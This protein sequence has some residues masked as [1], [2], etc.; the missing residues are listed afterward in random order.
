VTTEQ[1]LGCAESTFLVV[2]PGLHAQ[3]RVE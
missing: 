2:E 1:F 3:W